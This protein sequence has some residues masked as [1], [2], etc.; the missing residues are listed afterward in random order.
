MI[1]VTYRQAEQIAAATQDAYSCDRYAPDQWVAVATLLLEEG[2]TPAQVEWIMRS[3]HM[4]WAGDCATYA[5]GTMQSEAFRGYILS[6]YVGSFAK[7]IRTAELELA[8]ESR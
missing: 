6:P 2:A 4:R 8:K 5:Y 3:K 7:I 1:A